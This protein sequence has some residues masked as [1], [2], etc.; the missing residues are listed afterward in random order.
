MTPEQL[1][2]KV[3]EGIEKEQKKLNGL[4]EWL[5][6][7]WSLLPKAVKDV[8]SAGQVRIED[9]IMKYSRYIEEYETQAKEKSL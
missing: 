4:N 5:E 8:I 1:L 6:S 3:R 2:E 7:N 9:R